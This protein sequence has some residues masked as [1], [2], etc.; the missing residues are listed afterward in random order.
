MTG[1]RI[2]APG[3]MIRVGKGGV[4]K[5]LNAVYGRCPVTAPHDPKEW[6]Q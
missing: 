6:N 4:T 2:T 5:V 1:H 3:P